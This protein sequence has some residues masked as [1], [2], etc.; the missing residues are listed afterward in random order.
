MP[1]LR[2]LVDGD[3]VWSDLPYIAGQAGPKWQR[4]SDIEICA[5]AGGMRSGDP[6]VT[7]RINLPD[8]TVALGETSLAL[9]LTAADAFKARHGDPRDRVPPAY[10]GNPR[11]G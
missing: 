9:L 5:L 10:P 11:R 2:I 3:G 7:I 6:S 8:G 4:T 1:A